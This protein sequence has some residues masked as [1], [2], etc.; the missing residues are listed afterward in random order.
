MIEAIKQNISVGRLN[1]AI[2]FQ[3]QLQQNLIYLGTFADEQSDV[4]EMK[5]SRVQPTAQSSQLASLSES[6]SRA[7]A[8]Q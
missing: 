7:D 4:R 3:Y 5:F 2:K 6:S 8:A 1:D